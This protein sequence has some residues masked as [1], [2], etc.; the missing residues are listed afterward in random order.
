[1]NRTSGLVRYEFDPR[2]DA[3][4]QKEPDRVWK[5]AEQ[6]AYLFDQTPPF[7]AGKGWDYSDTNYLVV[8]LTIEKVLGERLFDAL[9]TRVHRRHGV[10]DVAAA[11]GRKLEGPGPGHPVHRQL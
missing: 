10:V 7:E 6:L 9:R 5:P 3:A 1:M 11:D 4:L 2:F 8:G